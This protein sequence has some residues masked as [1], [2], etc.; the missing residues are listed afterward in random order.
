MKKLL[1]I[2]IITV[3]L[4]GLVPF[5]FAAD[6][7]A[8][9][10]IS[11]GETKQVS[12]SR[13]QVESFFKFVP[14]ETAEYAFYSTLENEEEYI[15]TYGYILDEDG[16]V[17]AKNDDDNMRMGVNFGVRL[18]LEK[19]KTYI[20]ASRLYSPME[21][22]DYNVSVVKTGAAAT[23][24]IPEKTDYTLYVGDWADIYYTFAPYA[25]A[26]EGATITSS[27]PAVIRAVE[28]MTVEAVSVGTATVALTSDNGLTANVNFT[29]AAPKTLAV[30]TPYSSI[31]ENNGDKQKFVFTPAESGNYSVVVTSSTYGYLWVEDIGSDWGDEMMVEGYFEAGRDYAIELSAENIAFEYTIEISK[32]SKA[33]DFYING[34]IGEVQT[35]YH[36][37]TLEAYGVDGILEGDFEWSVDDEQTAEIVSIA[38]NVASLT[39]LKEGTVT[40]SA[41]WNGITHTYTVT[42]KDPA[43]LTLAQPYTEN[44]VGYDNAVYIAF[45]PETSGMYTFTVDDTANAPIMLAIDGFSSTS[46]GYYR[47]YLEAGQTYVAYAYRFITSYEYDENITGDITI[48]VKAC[49]APVG[50]VIDGGDAVTG[51]VNNDV[52]LTVS[53]TNDNGVINSPIT[54]VVD[55]TEEYEVNPYGDGANVYFYKEGEFTVTASAGM[56]TDSIKVKVVAPEKIKLNTK[57]NGSVNESKLFHVVQ[58][59]VEKAGVYTVR[60]KS[61]NPV[62]VDAAFSNYGGSVGTDVEIAVAA[63]TT[64][65]TYVTVYGAEEADANFTIELVDVSFPMGVRP[66]YS[67]I[68]LGIGEEH[69]PYLIFEPATVREEIDTMASSDTNVVMIEG[70]SIV[71]VG[72]G[73][74]TVTVITQ[75]GLKT[76]IKVKVVGDDYEWAQDITL[77]KNE[78]KLDA[79]KSA[80]LKA[81]VQAE[82]DKKVIW[83][84]EDQSVARVDQNGR[85]T[86][87]AA[88]TTYIIATVDAIDTYCAVTV[89]A[90]EIKKA[91][92][93]FTDVESGKW[94]TKAINYA[95]TY[96]FIKGKT[97]TTFN[98]E[99]KITRAEFITILARIA[100]VNTSGSA[101]KVETKFTDVKTGK[102]YTAAIKW[103]N[104]N[105]IVNGTSDTIF[106][107][108][109]NI[110]RQDICVMV[111]RF[112]KYMNVELKASVDEMKFTDASTISKYAKNA[113]TT[114]QK[115]G[116]I[117]GYN[118]GSFGPAKSATRAEAAQILYLFH[119]NFIA[120]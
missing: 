72:E 86:G 101:N 56:L 114:C 89:T 52:Y 16:K 94:Y 58:L 53:A 100:G 5:A 118:D 20:L 23:A 115:A 104:E 70:D 44:V 102:F 30:D 27:N 19:D 47:A 110:S 95:Y 120:K 93:K 92:E 22:G 119:S 64:E 31:L 54:W 74:A 48:A 2:L 4:I 97:E 67:E 113:V 90:P 65:P 8:Y 14:T 6:T 15:D 24:I 108:E 75:Y 61:D 84:S 10:A 76:Q 38:S 42:G 82:S 78:L 80:T 45:T 87:I 66:V 98:R 41:K 35:T 55:G 57:V 3:M 39:F 1:S 106:G 71:A 69:Y 12:A 68:T 81:T 83:S 77:D 107:T 21:K 116:L 17:I 40:V 88:G 28:G 109:A 62:C 96:G 112:A 29:V 91:T 32:S 33:T 99:D 50:I 60:V 25:C 37:Q 111:T 7:S 117:K 18:Q 9:P 79:G 43:T 103:A 49:E 13:T 85:V 26:F 63:I 11:L 36:A 105:G 59:D 73:T 34:S 46:D 51:Y